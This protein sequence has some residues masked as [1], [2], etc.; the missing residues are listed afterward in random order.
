MPE[1]PAVVEKLTKVRMTILLS[2]KH[3][4]CAIE[5]LQGFSGI[6]RTLSLSRQDR[7]KLS[8]ALLGG[9]ILIYLWARDCC[10][11]FSATSIDNGPVAYPLTLRMYVCTS[12]VSAVMS[13]RV[14]LESHGC[15]K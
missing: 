6:N 9:E 10:K 11:E 1:K 13:E 2:R 8:W 14:D 4:R 15:S 12:Y 7:Y 5:E 3:D